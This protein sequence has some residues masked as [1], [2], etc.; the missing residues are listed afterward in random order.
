MVPVMTNE[1]QKTVKDILGQ[2]PSMVS[3]IRK[4][5]DEDAKRLINWADV[6]VIVE[7][8]ESSEWDTWTASFK[9]QKMLQWHK[10]VKLLD[11]RLE[12]SHLALA[13]ETSSNR[14]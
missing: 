12:M 7:I 1:Q 8:L 3:S 5:S 4:V 6:E 13:L 14:F 10:E 11:S 2:V 9:L